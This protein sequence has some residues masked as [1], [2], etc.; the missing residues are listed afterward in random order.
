MGSKYPL[1]ILLA[2]D[3]AVNQMVA[4]HMLEKLGYHADVAADGLEVLEALH[5]QKYDVI[6]MDRQMPEMDGVTAT[7]NIRSE[8]PKE[9]QPR[10]IAMTAEALEGDRERFPRSRNG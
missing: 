1:S 9:S 5:R 4:L 6:L 8:W 10:I 2:E 7:K 3:D